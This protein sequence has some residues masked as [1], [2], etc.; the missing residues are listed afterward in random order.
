MTKATN[1]KKTRTK[2]TKHKTRDGEILTIPRPTTKQ[3]I[4]LGAKDTCL[5]WSLLTLFAV[6][7]IYS[8]CYMAGAVLIVMALSL[9]F[10]GTLT[11]NRLLD[12]G[13]IPI[14]N[15]NEALR[16]RFG[17]IEAIGKIYQDKI[18]P[19]SD[20]TP[21]DTQGFQYLDTKYAFPKDL[22]S[23]AFA[24]KNENGNFDW[25]TFETEKEFDPFE[26]QISTGRVRTKFFKEIEANTAFENA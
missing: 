3:R 11:V 24:L 2:T 5:I 16:E 8:K 4:L 14:V 12:L 26:R 7:L 17:K 20:S 1:T 15:I 18:Y 13:E 21:N 10:F 6:I 22:E 19:L 25:F 23:L 9:V